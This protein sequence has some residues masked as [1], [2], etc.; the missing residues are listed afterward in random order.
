MVEYGIWTWAKI[1]MFDENLEPYGNGIQMWFCK[2]DSSARVK[3]YL[4]QQVAT[5]NKCSIIMKN[6]DPEFHGTKVFAD[7]SLHQRRSP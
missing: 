6:Q 5:N 2:A 7:P 3:D 1:R 4:G